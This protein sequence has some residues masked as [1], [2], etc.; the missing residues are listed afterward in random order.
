MIGFGGGRLRRAVLAVGVAGLATLTGGVAGASGFVEPAFTGTAADFANCPV[1]QIYEVESEQN[2]CSHSYVL[3][4]VVQIGHLTTPIS[5][6]GATFDL[7]MTM[8]APGGVCE[9]SLAGCAVSGGHGILTGP[10]QPVP[11]GFL[12]T[13]GNTQLTGVKAKPEWAVSVPAYTP[14]GTAG[15]FGAPGNTTFDLYNLLRGSGVGVTLSLKI[16]LLS[17]FLGPNCYIGSAANPIVISLTDGLTAPP[18]PAQPIRGTRPTTVAFAHGFVAGY[19]SI[20]LVGNSFSVPVATGCGTSGGGLV[21]A[22]INHKLGLPSAA[23][24]NAMTITANA[25]IAG[26]RWL[27]EAGWTG[28]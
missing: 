24:N 20:R 23:G 7:G 9:P 3:S 18:P 4:G 19:L 1:P 8:L 6:A 17:P 13:I 27:L 10:A 5:V 15:S 21:N 22:A 28:E 14:F 2:S 16:H 11:S 25:D 12:G 26:A